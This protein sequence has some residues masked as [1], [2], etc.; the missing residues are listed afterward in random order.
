MMEEWTMMDMVREFTGS[1]IVTVAE[2]F[3]LEP[4]KHNILLPDILRHV[5][6]TPILSSGSISL[7]YCCKCL[8]NQAQ[9]AIFL[10]TISE[11]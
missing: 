10:S 8:N 5:D 4:L 6:F 1:F 7:I 3:A 9:T 11:T 2:N